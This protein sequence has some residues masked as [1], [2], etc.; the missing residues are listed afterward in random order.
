MLYT[1]T[2]LL[3]MHNIHA[4]I[5]IPYTLLLLPWFATDEYTQVYTCILR[6]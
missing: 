3:Y 4:Y 2:L 1:Y 5:T 6:T